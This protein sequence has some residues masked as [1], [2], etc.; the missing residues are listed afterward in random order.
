MSDTESNLNSVV[1]EPTISGQPG[2]GAK[3]SSIDYSTL[4]AEV[5]KR[6]EPE[7]DKKVQSVKDRRFESLEQKYAKTL[8]KQGLTPE[9]AKSIADRLP[10]PAN[11]SA[12]PIQSQPV[13]NGGGGA[14]ADNLLADAGIPEDDPDRIAFG[15]KNYASEAEKKDELLRI[16]TRKLNP[17]VVTPAAVAS[18]KGASIP[19]ADL[20]VEYEKAK[21]NIKRGDDPRALLELQRKYRDQGLEV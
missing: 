2:E 15:Q 3:Q 18:P 5:L 11:T 9:E 12:D 20:R 8:E 16:M 13:G 7:I 14:S 21:A 10:K 1:Q 6:L 19:P 4:A 17:T